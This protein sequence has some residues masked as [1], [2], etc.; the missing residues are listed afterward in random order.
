MKT[1]KISLIAGAVLL[2]TGGVVQAADL[3]DLDVTVRVVED[4]DARDMRNEL[5]LPAAA[6]DTAREHAEDRD[7]EHESDDRDSHDENDGHDDDREDHDE[8]REEHDD[9]R[10]DHD[11][12]H[13]D[14]DRES[15]DDT[16]DLDESPEAPIADGV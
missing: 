16:G 6:S 11:E 2:V 4:D 14:D 10:E 7:R 12:D 8:N 1:F 15:Q 5:T 13:H 3:D 9:D